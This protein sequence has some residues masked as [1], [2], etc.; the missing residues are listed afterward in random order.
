MNYK[1]VGDTCIFAEY[2]DMFE[3]TK[4]GK[5]YIHFYD[6]DRIQYTCLP[7]DMVEESGDFKERNELEE[8]KQDLA[9][10]LENIMNSNGISKLENQ[11]FA[12]I[13]RYLGDE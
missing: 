8:Y 7:K 4:S 1:Y 9:K 13:L 2:G 3:L 12:Y 10:H 5:G 6:E 11:A